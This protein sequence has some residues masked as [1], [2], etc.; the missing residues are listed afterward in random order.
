MKNDYRCLNVKK[1]SILFLNYFSSKRIAY[2]A[3]DYFSYK[4]SLYCSAVPRLCRGIPF[5]INRMKRKKEFVKHIHLTCIFE[6]GYE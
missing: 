3:N 1:K 4:D 5:D 2:F 6:N